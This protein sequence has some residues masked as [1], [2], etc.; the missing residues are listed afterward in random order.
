MT[1]DRD[2]RI[3]KSDNL[4]NFIN[5]LFHVQ[6]EAECV[7]GTTKPSWRCIERSEG[8]LGVVWMPLGNLL[9]RV[10]G[11]FGACWAA[12]GISWAA[13][14]PKLILDDSYT[15]LGASKGSW[16]DLG[17]FF[18]AKMEAPHREATSRYN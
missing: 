7:W 1:I 11:V 10:W 4:T 15:L 3:A 9:E 12:L 16:I 8:D 14:C 5:S 6:T 2:L 13:L 18:K 17:T